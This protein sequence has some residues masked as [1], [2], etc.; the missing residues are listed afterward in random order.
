MPELKGLQFF[1]ALSEKPP[2][3]APFKILSI[4]LSAS[5]GQA[6]TNNWVSLYSGS[7]AAFN[8][9][10]KSRIESA[11]TALGV[12]HKVEKKLI[13]VKVNDRTAVQDLLIEFLFKSQR[14]SDAWQN[15]R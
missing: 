8:L 10:D 7:E 5:A 11:L 4:L 14:R 15:T 12:E 3:R 13:L 6:A 1:G 2:V 9:R